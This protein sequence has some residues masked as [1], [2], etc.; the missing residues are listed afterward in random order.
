MSLVAMAIEG[1][2][3]VEVYL[4][5]LE[6]ANAPCYAVAETKSIYSRS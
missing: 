3:Y 5:L 2:V 4:V 1:W 6:T